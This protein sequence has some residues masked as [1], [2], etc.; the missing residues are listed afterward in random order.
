MTSPLENGL[1]LASARRKVREQA[2]ADLPKEIRWRDRWLN[3]SLLLEANPTGTACFIKVTIQVDL[4]KTGEII[5]C[6]GNLTVPGSVLW[7]VEPSSSVGEVW[8]Q[9]R[10]KLKELAQEID[11]FLRL[12]V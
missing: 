11:D 9:A 4:S 3:R 10:N 2:L 1:A 5:D 7:Y 8:E 12:E 6:Q